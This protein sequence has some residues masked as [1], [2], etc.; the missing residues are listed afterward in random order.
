MT[1]EFSHSQGGTRT[2]ASSEYALELRA[3]SKRFGSVQAN[4][5]VDFSVR[6]G[7][8]RGLVGENG[9]GKS[10]LMAIASGL[11]SPDSGEISVNGEP[12]A[13]KGREDAIE[14]GI[15][16]VHQQFMLIDDCSV[17]Q[18]VVLGQPGGL[19]L[20]TK[21]LERAVVA[22]R[23]VA[24]LAE[25]HLRRATRQLPAAQGHEEESDRRRRRKREDHPGH[26]REPA[27]EELLQII[28]PEARVAE[29]LHPRHT[30]HG[31]P[32]FRRQHPPGH[33]H[34][35]AGWRHTIGEHLGHILAHR[36]RALVPDRLSA[37]QRVVDDDESNGLCRLSRHSRNSP[38]SGH[39]RA[40]D[41]AD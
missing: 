4:D 5:R 35:P 12:V 36:H 11:Y 33:H 22:V 30:E 21:E 27:D 32:V 41:R 15:N 34:H 13:F 23:V 19:V 38:Q 2:D 14:R 16:M 25:E 29:Q 31:R 40:R 28:L 9:A 10:T 18:N 37:L 20:K 39:P 3:V 26:Q 17:A 6:S 1:G 24:R 7:E 8:I